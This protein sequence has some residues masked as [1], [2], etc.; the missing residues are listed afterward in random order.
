MKFCEL[1]MKEIDT[2]DGENRCPKCEEKPIAKKRS[3][4]K[5]SEMDDIMGSLGMKRVRGALGGTYY[6]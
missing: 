1:C 5:R 4:L 6:E 2:R 3:R